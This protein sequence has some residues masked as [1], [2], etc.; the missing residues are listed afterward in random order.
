[1]SSKMRSEP[2]KS[3]V[4]LK[5]RDKV[6]RRNAR[7]RH[8]VKAVNRGYEDLAV[9]LNE[10]EVYKNKKLTKA[11]TLKAAIEYIKHLE[12]ILGADG[13]TPILKDERLSASSST[14]TSPYSATSP[15]SAT[16]RQQSPYQQYSLQ[17]GYQMYSMKPEM[18][19]GVKQEMA[20]GQYYYGQQ[21]FQQ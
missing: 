7:E 12:S 21:F 3:T 11:D 14:T 17:D 8:R 9:M 18:Y 13:S 2:K 15:F 1:M 5:C 10:W 19:G 16:S 4:H 20:P 6:E